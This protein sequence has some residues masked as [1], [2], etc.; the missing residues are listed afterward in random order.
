MQESLVRE[1]ISYYLKSTEMLG[2]KDYLRDDFFCRI[3]GLEKLGEGERGSFYHCEVMP[4]VLKVHTRTMSKESQHMEVKVERCLTNL[5][6]HTY[7]G[8]QKFS[9]TCFFFIFTNFLHTSFCLVNSPYVFIHSF[10][11]FSDNL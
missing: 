6:M 4:L 3:F 11:A 1:L 2:K 8:S 9:D 10:D 5:Q 7:T